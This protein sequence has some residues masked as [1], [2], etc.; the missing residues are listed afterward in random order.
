MTTTSARGTL[1]RRQAELN[2]EKVLDAAEELFGR[3]GFRET[4]L[5]QVAERCGM[6]VGALYLHLPNKEELLRA[7]IDRRGL[8]LMSRI[9]SFVEADGLGIDLLTGLV[10]TEIGF[11]RAFPDFGRLISRLFSSGF[12]VAPRL[13]ADVAHGYT[14]AIQLAAEVIRRGQL[15]GTICPGDTDSLARLL[16]AMVGSHRNA[17]ATRPDGTAGIAEDQFVQMVRRAFANVPGTG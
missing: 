12:A 4:S 15:D 8:A 3:N 16:A 10:R 9:R 1:R 2:R 7:V 5:R 11:Y 14:A 13:G 6:S 17:E